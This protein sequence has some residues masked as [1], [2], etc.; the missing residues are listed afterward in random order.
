MK[1]PWLIQRAK[2]LPKQNPDKKGI[3]R[4]LSFDYMGS[5][6]FEFGALPASLKRIRDKLE[7]YMYSTML[8]PEKKSLVVFHRKEDKD[9]VV[10][11]INSIADGTIHLKEWCDLKYWINSVSNSPIFKCENDFWW[12][13]VNDYMFWKDN[14]QFTEQ[15]KK[16]IRG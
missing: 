3:D 6:E 5:A 2:F 1:A 11:N 14:K 12:D 9:V 7:D 4:I 10:A 16:L 13:I 8:L 15:F